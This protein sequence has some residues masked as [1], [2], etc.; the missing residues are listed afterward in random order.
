ME[1][2]NRIRHFSSIRKTKIIVSG[3]YK[4]YQSS[5]SVYVEGST[6]S[7]ITL[8]VKGY[9]S[10]YNSY[11]ETIMIPA[12]T[13]NEY[14]IENYYTDIDLYK[15]DEYT[16]EEIQLSLDL[17]RDSKHSYEVVHGTYENLGNA[18]GDDSNPINYLNVS[19][20]GTNKLNLQFDYTVASDIK[21][22][23][24]AATSN[25]IELSDKKT[26]S[27]WFY[28]GNDKG[29]ITAPD[30]YKFYMDTIKLSLSKYSDDVYEYRIFDE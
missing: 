19:G 1:R 30:G 9:D 12:N 26:L 20:I 24:T 29:T 23:A 13:N 21:L 14:V 8:Y 25:D 3:L 5:I 22:S 4:N 27:Y 18:G 15:Y 10:L 16:F 2:S 17:Y 28:K 6:S 11:T 7:K